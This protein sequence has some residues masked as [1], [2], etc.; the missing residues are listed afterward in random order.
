[1]SK[2]DRHAFK[3]AKSSLWLRACL[4][5]CLLLFFICSDIDNTRRPLERR[6]ENKEEKRNKKSAKEIKYSDKKEWWQ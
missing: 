6:Q 2:V 4:F 5:V 1:M 3:I